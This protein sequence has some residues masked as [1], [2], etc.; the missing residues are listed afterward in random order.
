MRIISDEHDY[1]DTALSYG[2]DP[3]IKF[4]RKE[5][6]WDIH[7]IPNDIKEIISPLLEIVKNMPTELLLNTNST[8]QI[9]RYLYLRNTI[10]F[11]PVIVGFCGKIH[12][13][14]YSTKTNNTIASKRIS[15]QTYYDLQTFV[16][17]YPE[18]HLKE[19]KTTREDLNDI[20]NKKERHLG[21][22]R[23]TLTYDNWSK[24]KEAENKNY[25][26]IFIKLKTPIFTL[27]DW[28]R[29]NINFKINSN[30]KKFMFFQIKDSTQAF[31]DISMYLG[32][33]LALENDPIPLNV[34]DKEMLYKKGFD[35]MSFKRH[36]DDPKMPSY[37]KKKKG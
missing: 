32:N 8:K 23:M 27:I 12:I 4:I 1:Y 33:Q 13:G 3:N 24:I 30:L 35:D 19:S 10:Q 6:E 5:E 2:I 36:K 18:E 31:Q 14:L 34:S 15:G 17:K 11:Y 22:G 29:T 20:L 7:N 9:N 26:D 37:N 25:D 21:F 16:E 28:G